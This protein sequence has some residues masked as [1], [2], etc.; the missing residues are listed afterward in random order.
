VHKRHGIG[1]LKKSV[2]IVGY[3][4]WTAQRAQKACITNP[5]LLITDKWNY[6][7]RK[8][9]QGRIAARVGFSKWGWFVV[10][11]S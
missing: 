7:Q 11:A 8:V 9:Y 2:F 6:Q 1:F 3:V 4:F 5:R 10:S